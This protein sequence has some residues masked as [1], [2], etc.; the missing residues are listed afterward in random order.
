[1]SL[2]V[3]FVL[4]ALLVS[5]SALAALRLAPAAPP[6]LRLMLACVGLSAWL[7]PWSSI[8]FPFAASVGPGLV[9]LG[10][11]GEQLAAVRQALMA[12]AAAS[13]PAMSSPSAWW[14]LVFL[15]GLAWFVGDVAAY[16]TVLG[17][18]RSVSR[19]G[20][21]L[22]RLLPPG[23][24]GSRIRVVPDSSIVA[25][26]GLLRPTIFI[27]DRIVDEDALRAA[28]THEACHAR[29][30]DPLW[31][32]LVTLI[33][34][35]YC[36][37][38][39]V[40]ALKRHAILAIEAGCDEACAR[41]LGRPQYRGTLARLI[42]EREGPRGTALAPSLHTPGLNVMRLTLLGRVPRVDGRSLIAVLLVFGAGIGGVAWSSP[43]SMRPWLGDWIEVAELSHWGYEL[44]PPIS[45]RFERSG[46]GLTRIHASGG[47]FVESADFRC[48]GRAYP[49][50]DAAGEPALT[51]VCTA[52]DPRTH[53]YVVQRANGSGLVA[54]MT[55]TISRD[56][57]TMELT[58]LHAAAG[59]TT[60][61]T[62]TLS[63]LR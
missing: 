21:E 39:V 25:V 52:I 38:P 16:R 1:V 57:E 32:M 28:L 55:E 60:G 5:L 59:G 20:G 15:P 3:D 40:L 2:L 9:W 29:R 27:G 43:G 35:L 61:A 37:N 46:S 22:A 51:L 23:L 14:L 31:L 45:R 17:R 13:A 26:A 53:R 30:R 49:A 48:D 10:E 6:G 12:T 54:D 50:R 58:V 11:G 7:V 63:R 8:G 44:A 33:A 42:L 18:W 47:A 62:R 41:R 34:R 24:A 4:P 36:F 56:G 19:S